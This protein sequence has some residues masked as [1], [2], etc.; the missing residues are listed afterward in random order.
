MIFSRMATVRF[1]I[2]KKVPRT[3][4][5]VKPYWV[6]FCNGQVLC[7]EDLFFP[8]AFDTWNLAN[9]C[10]E[11]RRYEDCQI[12]EFA[13]EEIARMCRDRQVPFDRFVLIDKPAQLGID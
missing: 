5:N 13:L 3:V 8:L 9:L 12:K 4:I 10:V 7:D 2:R 11:D 1:T 6:V